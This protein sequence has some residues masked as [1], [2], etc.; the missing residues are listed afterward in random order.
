MTITIAETSCPAPFVLHY[1]MVRRGSKYYSFITS[2]VGEDKPTVMHQP[3]KNG[4]DEMEELMVQEFRRCWDS[5]PEHH[6]NMVL[7][8]TSP[9]LRKLLV[10][11]HDLFP[12]LMLRSVAT[13][14]ALTTTWSSARAALTDSILRFDMQRE[15]HRRMSRKGQRMVVATDASKGTHSPAIGWAAACS[16]GQLRSGS[17]HGNSIEEGEFHAVQRAIKNFAAPH[18]GILD[19]LTDSLE[20]YRFINLPHIRQRI[21]NPCKQATACLNAIDRAQREGIVVNVHWVRG[22]NGHILNDFADRAAVN[23]RRCTQ[24]KLGQ[25]HS[26]SLEAGIRSD[27]RGEVRGVNNPVVLLPDFVGNDAR[28]AKA[29]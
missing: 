19:V 1:E 28:E 18:L 12:G 20:V 17:I 7:Y 15:E 25:A 6:H 29:A 3:L 24:W 5:H 11:Q 21:D 10:E 13:G 2:A 22:H 27:L 4:K 23:A 8:T 9:I 14:P 16:D 26:Q